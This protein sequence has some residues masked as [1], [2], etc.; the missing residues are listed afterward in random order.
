M[1][2][3]GRIAKPH[4]LRGE[5]IVALTTN[6]SDRLAP[7]AVFGHLTV[8]SVK[9]HQHRFIVKFD[10][11]D[12]REAAESLHGHVLEAEP[13]DDPDALWVHELIGCRVVGADGTD[14]GVV[15]AV[16]ANPAS[17]LLVLDTGHLVP[18]RFVTGHE[19]GQVT[20]DAPEGLFDES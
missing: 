16:E 9:P 20:I 2:E 13:L 17:D 1:L 5:V 6:R 4:G 19:R 7:G 10:G 12:T 11:V 15:E 3:I 14:R 8:V 18:L